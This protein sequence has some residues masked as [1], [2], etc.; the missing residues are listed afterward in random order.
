M[1]R[2]WKES[3]QRIT[4][5]DNLDFQKITVAAV[6]RVTCRQGRKSEELGGFFGNPG[7][8][9]GGLHQVVAVLKK[10]SRFSI[11]FAA[12]AVEID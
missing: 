3:S 11:Y 4:C 2:H 7:R 10:I 9:D 8:N 6:L 5:F 12:K 1:G